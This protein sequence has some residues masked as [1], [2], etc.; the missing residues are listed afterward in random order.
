MSES[1]DN[2]G[3]KLTDLIKDFSDDVL[4][5][6]ETRLD[7]TADQILEYIK[8]PTACSGPPTYKSTGIQCFNNS[9][10]ANSLSLSGSI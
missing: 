9:W 5:S 10:F 7:E 1:I 8:W 3:I 2:L 4:A 6:I